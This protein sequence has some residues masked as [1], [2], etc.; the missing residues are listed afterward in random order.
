MPYENHKDKTM[1]IAVFASGRG[2]NFQAII[3]AVKS[4]KLKAKLALLVCD[5]PK[6][7]ALKRAKKSGIKVALVERDDF[8]S[9]DDFEKEIISHLWE[10]K[11]DLIVMAGFMRMLSAIFVRAY[12]GRIL[13]IHPA[14]LPAFK[15]SQAIKDAFDYG[16]KVTGVTVHFV[17]EEMDHGPIILQKEVEVDESDTLASLE[18]K[19]HRVEHKVYPEAIKLIVKRKVGILGRKV[20]ITIR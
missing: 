7:P 12:K 14:L 6:A 15:G 16:V 10:N 2:T 1:N 8:S 3:N 11:I 4:G 20:K 19:I 9:R 13:N 17:D 5:N 18:E